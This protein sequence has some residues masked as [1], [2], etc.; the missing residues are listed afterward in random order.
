MKNRNKVIKKHS[1][2]VIGDLLSITAGQTPKHVVVNAKKSDKPS[3][4]QHRKEKS[5]VYKSDLINPVYLK[6]AQQLQLDLLKDDERRSQLYMDIVL[7]SYI[8]FMMDSAYKVRMV[9]DDKEHVLLGKLSTLIPNLQNFADFLNINAFQNVQFEKVN[10][11]NESIAQYNQ[12]VTEKVKVSEDIQIYAESKRELMHQAE[13]ITQET[14]LKYGW[15]D[16]F[17]FLSHPDFPDKKATLASFAKVCVLIQRLHIADL[18]FNNIGIDQ[19]GIVQ[20]FDVEHSLSCLQ[21]REIWKWNEDSYKRFGWQNM[22]DIA[23]QFN[24]TNIAMQPNISSVPFGTRADEHNSYWTEC[25]AYLGNNHRYFQRQ[26]NRTLLKELLCPDE[27]IEN[28]C[29]VHAVAGCS[30]QAA[31]IRDCLQE[32]KPLLKKQLFEDP[33]FIQY[34]VQESPA[35]IEEIV[36]EFTHAERYHRHYFEDKDELLANDFLQNIRLAYVE[37]MT[38]IQDKQIWTFI[39]PVVERPVLTSEQISELI[40]KLKTKQDYST[41]LKLAYQS[42][43]QIITHSDFNLDQPHCKKVLQNIANTPKFLYKLLLGAFYT[44]ND[45]ACMILLSHYI[46]ANGPD[47]L[48]TADQFGRSLLHHAAITVRVNLTNFLLACGARI[49]L[50]VGNGRPVLLDIISAAEKNPAL[51]IVPLMKSSELV[52]GYKLIYL[53][54]TLQQWNEHYQAKGMAIHK[55]VVQEGFLNTS[56]LKFNT[57]EKLTFWKELSKF[58]RIKPRLNQPSLKRYDQEVREESQQESGA[59]ILKDLLKATETPLPGFR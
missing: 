26:V 57:L 54:Q 36:A 42:F 55:K 47:V 7:G 24:F 28:L 8:Y 25:K 11:L 41:S 3:G 27:F 32:T 43:L 29:R 12:D 9:T 10:A 46:A 40:Q 4:S 45:T 34:L 38:E 20:L 37:M 14:Q 15:A 23:A 17:K 51:M 21:S 33:Q 53:G 52:K 1:N 30:A 2:L 6:L 22:R 16:V 48:N 31:M 58:N 13:Q 35:D 59:S 5:W 56:I 44:N 50:K 39:K 49:D 18:H 19:N